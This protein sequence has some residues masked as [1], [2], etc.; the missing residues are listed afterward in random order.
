MGNRP[1]K[2]KR[3]PSGYNLF[4]KKCMGESSSELKGKPFGAAAPFMKKCTQEW[5]GFSESEKQAFK[6]K[7]DAC[8]LDESSNTWECPS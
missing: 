2:P 7:S 8:Q 1:K 4:I 5:K 6:Q 3:K